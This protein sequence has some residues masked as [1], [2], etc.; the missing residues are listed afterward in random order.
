MAN[1]VSDEELHEC[2]VNSSSSDQILMLDALKD[3]AMARAEIKHANTTLLE[4]KSQMQDIR[5]EIALL[6]TLLF[7]AEQNVSKSD[8]IARIMRVSEFT[9]VEGEALQK[10]LLG[11]IRG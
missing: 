7:G 1:R 6:K 3:L 11:R 8:W 5:A 9:Q 4:A 10:L 2:L